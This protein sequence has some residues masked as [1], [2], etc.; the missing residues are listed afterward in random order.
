MTPSE[1]SR[2]PAEE[3]TLFEVLI[4]HISG[5]SVIIAAPCNGR[6]T[7]DGGFAPCANA[8]CLAY[9]VTYHQHSE[10]WG[11]MDHDTMVVDRC[12]KTGIIAASFL[13]SIRLGD[14]GISHCGGRVLVMAAPCASL[15]NHEAENEHNVSLTRIFDILLQGAICPGFHDWGTLTLGRTGIRPEGLGKSI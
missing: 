8:Q 5:T 7:T 4:D 1:Q 13:L 6:R 12:L 3:V 2:H 10:G 15:V 11:Q 9:Q 14:S